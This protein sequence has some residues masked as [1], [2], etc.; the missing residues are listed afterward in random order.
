MVIAVNPQGIVVDSEL[1]ADPVQGTPAARI[2]T[3]FTLSRLIR[4]GLICPL[5]IKNVPN[6]NPNAAIMAASGD[7]PNSDPSLVY[8]MCYQSPQLGVGVEN[9]I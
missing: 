6:L 3:I 4:H 9:G 2:V 5:A 8:P 1:A 7:R